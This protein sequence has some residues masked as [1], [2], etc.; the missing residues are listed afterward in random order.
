MGK[1]TIK[2]NGLEYV[3][4]DTENSNEIKSLE[5]R[6]EWLKAYLDEKDNTINELEQKLEEKDFAINSLNERIDE[7]EEDNAELFS[8]N[9]RLGEALNDIYQVAK[10]YV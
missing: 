9:M 6:I 1:L 3:A 8:E 5:A 10:D 7:L 2:I 4:K